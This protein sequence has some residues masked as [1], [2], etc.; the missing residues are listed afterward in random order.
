[1]KGCFCL[2]LFLK[3]FTYS[4]KYTMN[5]WRPFQLFVLRVPTRYFTERELGLIPQKCHEVFSKAIQ[6]RVDL[7]SEKIIFIILGMG[8]RIF[9]P[10]S[11]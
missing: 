2:L 5:Q 8:I 7:I 4:L 10:I 3:D 11:A 9:K 1:M 6:N